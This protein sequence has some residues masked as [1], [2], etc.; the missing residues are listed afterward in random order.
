MP[1]PSTPKHKKNAS[2]VSKFFTV[3]SNIFSIGITAATSTT[4]ALASDAAATASDYT[5]KPFN[6]LVKSA[7]QKYFA[8]Q[9]AYSSYSIRWNIAGRKRAATEEVIFTRSAGAGTAAGQATGNGIARRNSLARPSGSSEYTRSHSFSTETV[10]DACFARV[11]SKLEQVLDH[12]DPL[13]CQSSQHLTFQIFR[14]E[15]DANP[16]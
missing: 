4:V 14:P 3:L 10:T 6:T 12:P 15:D 11:Q 9:I 7:T 2:S 1:K 5:V 8:P 13:Q 16:L